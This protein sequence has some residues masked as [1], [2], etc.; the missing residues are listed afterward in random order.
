MRTKLFVFL[1]IVVQTLSAT[2]YYVSQ[3]QGNDNNDGTS[4]ST[5]WK[6]LAKVRQMNFQ[7]GDV[8][9]FKRGD[10]WKESRELFIDEQGTL[11]NP[12]T[13]TDYGTG[14]KPII[15]MLETLPNNLPWTNEGNN[16]WTIIL[17]DN[18]VNNYGISYWSVYS[19]MLRMKINNQEVLGGY[20][21]DELGNDIPDT[22]RFYYDYENTKKLWLYSLVNPNNLTIEISTQ[23]YGIHIE[24]YGGSEGPKYLVIENF[25]VIGGNL[26]CV[27]INQGHD[28][29]LRNLEIG[30]QGNHG[31]DVS[32][33]AHDVI[34]E[35]CLIDSNY[36]FDYSQAGTNYSVSRRGPREG[37]YVRGAD[38]IEFK[39]N[40][41]YNFTHANMN[42]GRSYDD[43]LAE[44]CSFHGNYTH[45]DLAYGGRTVFERGTR[46]L[47]F[48]NNFIDGASVNNQFNGQNNHIHHNIIKDVKSPPLV[49][50]HDGWG[51]SF[52]PYSGEDV[53]NNIIE[54]NLIINCDSGGMQMKNNENSFVTDNI[55]RNNIFLD[56]GNPIQSPYQQNETSN[57][58][59]AIKI[60]GHYNWNTH[61]FDNEVTGNTFQN[62][63]IFC[64][65]G[66]PARI[67]YHLNNDD[68]NGWTTPSISV[69]DFNNQNGGQ[70]N[71]II[72]DNLEADPA[73]VDLANDDFHLMPNSSAI[74][75][76]IMPL[77]TIDK[78]GNMIPFAGTLPDIGVYEYQGTLS[79]E[80]FYNMN[81]LKIYP[82]PSSN[83]I[84][85][86]SNSDF[87]FKNYS[88]YDVTGKKVFTGL[89][90]GQSIDIS[91]LQK[92]IYILKLDNNVLRKK[93]VKFKFI[94]IN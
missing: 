86:S 52:Y 43:N 4:P 53:S 56:N 62:N 9:H 55:I 44:N 89:F 51:I 45:T 38:N 34:I 63:L 16:I 69:A 39:N 47:E 31:I 10:I 12:I 7:P 22:V 93:S 2:E 61:Q 6:T 36:H 60:A 74:D 54:N 8:I 50:Y 29:L 92:G 23:F 3:S 25:K 17:D 94:K 87:S 49:H 30:D 67:L 46:T 68:P 70:Y 80:N 78:D 5:P 13:F 24:K 35:D 59:L 33:R 57:I 76:G 72:S 64:S 58:N 32:R 18:L 77:A 91:N 1:L 40:E 90:H 75:A 71:D 73:F 28:I 15:N 82:N 79:V 85:V 19:K 41:I 21:S 48:Y 37:F 20:N 88:I 42:I 65:N 81:D 26:A 14:V 27:T 84:S 11:N 83:F 66:N